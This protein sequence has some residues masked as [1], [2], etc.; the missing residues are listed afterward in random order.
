MQKEGGNFN[1]HFTKG[2][3]VTTA[4]EVQNQQRLDYTTVSNQLFLN[5]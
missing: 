4:T 5:Y 2:K 1:W 3:Q